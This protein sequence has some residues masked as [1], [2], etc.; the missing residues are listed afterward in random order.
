MLTAWDELVFH[1]P[2]LAVIKAKELLQDGQMS[3]AYNVLE[4]L[5]EAM[6][7]SERKAVSSQQF[8]IQKVANNT[9]KSN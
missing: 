7:R 5:A 8:Q 3:E 2:Y 4:S 6:G 1:S 9:D